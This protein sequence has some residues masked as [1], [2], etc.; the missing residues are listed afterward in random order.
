MTLI[1]FSVP[2]GLG[3]RVRR[4]GKQPL[5]GIK[6]SGLELVPNLT[7]CVLVSYLGEDT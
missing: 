7:R 4:C 1:G 3:T 6:R 2:Q 5:E